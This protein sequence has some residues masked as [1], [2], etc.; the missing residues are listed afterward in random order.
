MIQSSEGWD[1][2]VA[3][4]VGLIVV[5]PLILWL[6]VLLIHLGRQRPLAV[7]PGIATGAGLGAPGALGALLATLSEPYPWASPRR[8]GSP[9]QDRRS[10]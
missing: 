6:G 9:W 2:L 1:V 10:R 5:A 7:A 4:V 8:L 3:Q